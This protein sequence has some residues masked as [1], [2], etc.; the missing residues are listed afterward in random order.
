MNMNL[1]TLKNKTVLITGVTGSIGYDLAA[2]L[3]KYDIMVI[4]I[5]SGLRNKDKI[6][7]LSK[8]KNFRVFYINQNQIKTI[9]KKCKNIKKIIGCPDIIVNSAGIFKFKKL[10]SY[11]IDDI[12]A[13]FNINILSPILITKYFIHLMSKKKS[14]IIINICSSS[15]YSG[16]GTYGHTIY[17]STKHA[18]L[19]FSRALD[20]EF[21]NKNIR[22]GTV[23]PAGV[24]SKMTKN[25]KD[26]KKTSLIS[27]KQVTDSII[28]LMTDKGN[29]IIYEIRL[30]R[31][32]R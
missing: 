22:I 4:G 13:S 2:R 25:R 28:Y 29:G 1:E 3:L 31:K 17:T 32:N 20:E 14:G 7:L 16:G 21:K 18:L 6:K 9:E 8:Y 15:S 24:K 27:L 5:C 19:G 26:I 11:S 23:S 30:W 10:T 12:I